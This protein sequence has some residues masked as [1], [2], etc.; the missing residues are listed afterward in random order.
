MLGLRTDWCVTVVIGDVDE[1]AVVDD[2]VV[3]E[4]ILLQLMIWMIDACLQ[5][6]TVQLSALL[7]DTYE[8]S[9]IDR[10]LSIFYH[11]AIY[12]VPAYFVNDCW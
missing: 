11:A 2:D 5:C 9:M 4:A 1:I 8:H 10:L 7:L 3:V 12:C 6:S